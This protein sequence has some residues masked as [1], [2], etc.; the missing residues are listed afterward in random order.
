MKICEKMAIGVRDVGPVYKFLGKKWLQTLQSGLIHVSRPRE[1]N[2]P[3]DCSLACTG[4][5]TDKFKRDWASAVN[6][7]G[8]VEGCEREALLAEVVE[9]FAVVMSCSFKYNGED[10]SS[11][12]AGNLPACR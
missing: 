8:L 9:D 5:F 12:L 10:H 6:I 3:F 1:F 7:D 11:P 2:D 4:R